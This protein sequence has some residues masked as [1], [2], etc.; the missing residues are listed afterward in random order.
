MWC[1]VRLFVKHV[2]LVFIQVLSLCSVDAWIV[3][4]LWKLPQ[5]PSCSA[6]NTNV[7]KTNFDMFTNMIAVQPSMAEYEWTMYQIEVE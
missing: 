1:S 3:A 2:K 4:L 6:N 5:M 7:D